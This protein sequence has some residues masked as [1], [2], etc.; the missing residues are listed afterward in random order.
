MINK[1]RSLRESFEKA[2]D[3]TSTLNKAQ[4][5]RSLYLGRRGSVTALMKELR[6]VSSE[7]KAS[8]GKEI[9]SLKNTVEKGIQEKLVVLEKDLGKPLISLM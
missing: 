9:N 5:L 8:I 4:E 6:N 1:I 2:L 3:S 7:E